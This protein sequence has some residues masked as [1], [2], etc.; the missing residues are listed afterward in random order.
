MTAPAALMSARAE[1]CFVRQRKGFEVDWNLNPIDFIAVLILLV[2]LLVNTAPIFS[3]VAIGVSALRGTSTRLLKGIEFKKIEWAVVLC[4][5]YWI[6]NY[7][8]STGDFDNFVSYD[9]VRN[10]GAML[11]SYTAI[12]FFLGWPLKIQQ[13]RTLWMV[14]LGALSFLAFAAI[15]Q[16]HSLPLSGIFAPLR[17]LEDGGMFN[18]WYRAHNTAG[19]VY[20]VAAVLAFALVQESGLTRKEK[21]FRW[22]LLLGCLGGLVQTYSRGGFLGFVAGAAIVFPLSKLRQSLKI[23]LTVG[24]AVFAI[25][26]MTNSGLARLDSITDRD[27]GTNAERIVLWKDA[28]EDFADSPLIGV[29][30]GRYNDLGTQYWGSKGIVWVMTK[31]KIVNSDNHAHNSY[32][33]FLAEG[34]IVGLWITMWVWWA[35]WKE[36]SFFMSHFPRSRLYWLEKGAAGALVAALVQAFTEHAIGRG[37]VVLVL[38]ALIGLTLAAARIEARTAKPGL[39]GPAATL[40]RKPVAVRVRREPLAVR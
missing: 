18:G 36:L 29:G 4:L 8:W 21:A 15:A 27:Y 31:G 38:D 3:I 26:V 30:Y 1:L 14:F 12:I 16:A 11:I 17:L 32:L 39:P 7:F 19:G 5:A 24:A 35:A 22:V 2:G 25:L 28:L 20:G 9:F 10:D 33:H 13:C 40:P 6:V 34:G 23:G 37:S